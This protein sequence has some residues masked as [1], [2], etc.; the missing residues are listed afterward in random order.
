MADF[1]EEQRPDDSYA[2]ILIN[3]FREVV[4]GDASRTS[5]RCGNLLAD[6]VEIF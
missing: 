1:L 6:D 4:E 2:T 5:P 3:L